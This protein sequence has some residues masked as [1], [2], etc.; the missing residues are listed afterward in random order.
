MPIYN[1]RHG[2]L[3]LKDRSGNTVEVKPGAGNF[4]IS[5]LEAGDREQEAVYNRGTFLERVPKRDKLYT[6]SITIMHDGALT[7]VD[8]TAVLDAVRGTGGW[9]GTTIDP[10]DTEHA[11]DFNLVMTRA[12]VVCTIA[13]ANCHLTADF[14]EGETANQLTINGDCAEGVTVS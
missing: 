6:F 2:V 13:G 11:L 3:R 4:S 14:G 12:G 7:A 5:A 1:F 8:R 9:T 10:S